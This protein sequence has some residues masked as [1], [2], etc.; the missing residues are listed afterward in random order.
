[1]ATIAIIS[2]LTFGILYLRIP[3]FA[4][5]FSLLVGQVLSVQASGDVYG[6][7]TGLPGLGRIEIVQIALLLLPFILTVVFLK[8]KAGRNKLLYELLPA[9][10]SAITL[11][12]LLY[13]NVQFIRTVLDI[14]SNDQFQ[15]YRSAALVL[16][17]V[18]GLVSVWLSFP[19]SEHR[20]KHHK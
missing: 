11:L 9:I 7:I 14:T 15:E 5:L 8:G 3:A 12:V 6:F 19:K 16:A 4:V 2:L 10:F 13:P 18:S 20:G 17:S 1:M